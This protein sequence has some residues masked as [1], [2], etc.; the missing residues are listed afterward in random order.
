LEKSKNMSDI[1]QVIG[2][3]GAFLVL[4]AYFLIS[5]KKIVV[6]SKVYQLMNLAGA[7][8]IGINAF[9]QEAWSSFGMQVAW[10]IIAI[11]AIFKSIR[12][13]NMRHSQH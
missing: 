10:G 6:N 4:L 8:G 12:N 1:N 3:V 5:H 13:I 2:W 7:A 11:I 9:N